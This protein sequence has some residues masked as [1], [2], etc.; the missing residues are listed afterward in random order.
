MVTVGPPQNTGVQRMLL[1][2]TAD[3]ESLGAP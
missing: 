1:R 3:A 2:A